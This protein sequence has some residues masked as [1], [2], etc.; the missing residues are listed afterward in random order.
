MKSRKKTLAAEI[1]AQGL[2][3]RCPNHGRRISVVAGLDSRGCK[4]EDGQV[5]CWDCGQKIAGMVAF[6]V[7]LNT[8][9]D[10]AYVSRRIG[11]EKP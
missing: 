11:E 3:P 7:T 6:S 8:Y 9:E 10:G 4:L 1:L 5:S 2:A